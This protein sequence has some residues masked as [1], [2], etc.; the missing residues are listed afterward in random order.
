MTAG[1][2]GVEDGVVRCRLLRRQLEENSRPLA[3]TEPA[4]SNGTKITVKSNGVGD[5]G[6]STAVEIFEEP[7][8]DIVR[9][10]PSPALDDLLQEVTHEAGEGQKL[11]GEIS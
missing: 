11:P 6:S 9:P 10:S 8:A 7:A 4:G 2:L 3:T 1:M 5:N